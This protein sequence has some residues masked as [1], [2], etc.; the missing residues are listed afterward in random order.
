MDDWLT[1]F[2]SGMWRLQYKLSREGKMR[3]FNEFLPLLHEAKTAALGPRD[4][5]AWY[6]VYI[7]TRSDSRGKGY[8]R[9]LIEHV[10]KQVR[11]V[12]AAAIAANNS[13]SEVW[14][15]TL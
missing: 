4:N 12:V 7:G 11:Q 3:F 9:K 15:R 13:W 2:R 10:T 1:I 14:N 8:C 6:L 5:E